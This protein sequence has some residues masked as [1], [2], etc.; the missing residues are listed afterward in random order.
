MNT[1]CLYAQVERFLIQV[2]TDNVA[3]TGC[4]FFAISRSFLLKVRPL[5]LTL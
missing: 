3:L 1:P 2:L 5:P 4:N